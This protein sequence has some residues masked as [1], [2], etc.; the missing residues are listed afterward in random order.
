MKSLA[1][2]SCSVMCGRPSQ[3]TRI[4]SD[5]AAYKLLPL[6]YRF[7]CGGQ[8]IT[9]IRLH[10]ITMSAFTESCLCDIYI[11]L[12]TQEEYFGLGSDFA[13]LP[14]SFNTIHFWQPNVQ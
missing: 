2:N 14:S 13:N 4:S 1:S 6:H 12:L 10:H 3:Q 8:F 9:R 7:H 11:N 5:A